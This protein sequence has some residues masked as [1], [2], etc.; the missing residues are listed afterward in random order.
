M[1]RPLQLIWD[2]T[3]QDREDSDVAYFGSLMYLGEIVAKLV[4]AGMVAAIQDDKDR[5]RYRQVHALIRADGIGKWAMVLDQILTGPSSQFFS[6]TSRTEQRELTQ[7]LGPGSWQYDATT[8][9]H[10]CC[11]AVNEHCEPLPQKLALSQSIHLFAQLRNKTRGHGAL[12]HDVVTALCPQ[13][14]LALKLLIDNFS[15]F[16]REWAYLH[17]NLSGKYRVTNLGES[18]LQFDYLRKSKS[19]LHQ[20]GVYVFFDCP[21]VVELAQSDTNANDFFLANGGYTQKRHEFISY[22]TGGTLYRDSAPFL[23][24]TSTLPASET[25]GTHFL[26]TVGSCFT[27]IPEPPS[28]FIHRDNLESELSRLLT[29]ERHDIITLIGSG[30]I[31]KTSLTLQV[32]NGVAKGGRYALIVWFSAR[33]IELTPQGAKQVRP[34]VLDIKDISKE[35]VALLQPSESQEPKFDAFNFLSTELGKCS[36]GP[37]LFVLDNFETVSNPL[38]VYKWFDTYLR[39]P[40]KLLITTRFRDFKGDY[41]VEVVGMTESECSELIATTA[42]QLR[43]SEFI[44]MEYTQH[45]FDESDGHP[46]VVKILLGDVAKERKLVPIRRIMA[47]QEDILTALFERTYGHLPPAA[48]RVFLTLSSWRSTIPLVAVQAVMLRRENERIDVVKA[49]E[50]LTRSSFVEIL[51]SDEHSDEFIHV[52]LTAATFGRG[53]LHA[54]PYR[55]AVEADTKLL[56]QFGAGQKDSVARGIDSHVKRFVSFVASKTEEDPSALKDYSQILEAVARHHPPAWLRVAEL[57]RDV[58]TPSML[59]A[60]KAAVRRYLEHSEVSDDVVPWKMLAD[61]CRWS[62]DLMGEAH[63]LVELSRRTD[64]EFSEISASANRLNAV[65]AESTDTMAPDEKKILVEQMADVLEMRIEE[66][67][68]TDRSR[69]AWLR[70]HIGDEPRARQHVAEGLRMDPDN[71]YCQ[72]LQER[73][74]R[75]RAF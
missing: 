37:A 15:L 30:G 71:Q 62:D 51:T 68:S 21:C 52:P 39:P 24:P 19:G 25:E 43:I 58:G 50:A 10:S 75:Q 13:L 14:E 33:D 65:L 27:N 49:V 28:D 32:L 53:K 73:L 36:I 56:H 1:L 72:R 67:N 26:D 17:R 18:T 41:P 20:D 31:G 16:R 35:Y 5:L 70:L 9:I 46:Y 64:V 29:D 7:K 38:E 44:T 12:A 4:V 74:D 54:S 11:E 61:C 48:Q 59:D 6:N 23:H 2:R 57:Y 22:I 69:L 55:A 40:N 42:R 45:L 66:G 60:A 3:Q 47:G 63:A 34:F 8:H